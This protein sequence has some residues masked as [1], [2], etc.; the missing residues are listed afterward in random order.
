MF[1]FLC[2][3]LGVPALMILGTLDDEV[4]IVTSNE[5]T[6]I[7]AGHNRIELPALLVLESDSL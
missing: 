7:L 6:Q 3:L 5:G 2:L 4:V 1:Q